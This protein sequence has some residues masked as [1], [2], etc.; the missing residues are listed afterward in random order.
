[1]YFLH[2][3]SSIYFRF[4]VVTGMIYGLAVWLLNYQKFYA[5]TY[6]RKKMRLLELRNENLPPMSREEHETL[7]QRLKE[8]QMR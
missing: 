2:Q 3:P 4:A 6:K 5:A 8:V 7:Q 1:V